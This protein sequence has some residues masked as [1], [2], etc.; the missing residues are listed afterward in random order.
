M[1]S[2]QKLDAHHKALT[3]NL[4]AS[5][6]GSFAEIGAGQEVARWF[7][8]VGGASAT[9]AKTISA[10]DKEVSD[11]LY[12]AGT[13]YVSRQRLEAMLEA[14]W[15]QLLAELNK[16]R[17]PQTRFFSFVDTVSARNYA[18]TN[19]P[20]GWVG[21]R[22]QLE[23]GGPPNDI[24]LH[25]NMLDPSN[26]LQQEAIGILGVNLIYTAFS[27][28][29]TKES[30]LAGLAQ[31]VVRERIEID[32]IDLRGSAFESW[33]LRSLPVELVHG[34]FAE[35]VFF[36]AQGPAVPPTESL[37][38]K[39]VVLAPGMFGHGDAEHSQVH[40]RLLASGIEELR[41]E[42]GGTKAA[43][44]GFFCLTA[45]SLAPDEPLPEVPD[46]LRRIDALLAAG[47]DVLLFRQ[48]ELYHMTSLVHRYTQEPVRFVAGLS[49]MI[50]AFEGIYGNL[51]GRLLE[52][53]ARL[54]AQNV[55]IYAYPMAATEL[56]ERL[57][58]VSAAGWEW[59]ET[60][61]MVSAAQL[62]RAPPL[63]H[64]FDYLLASNFLVPMQDPASLKAG[65]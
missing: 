33:D 64:L 58:G 28:L 26:L 23:P 49:L 10:Y 14:E 30:F 50:R 37:Y 55:R 54:F 53:L 52:A 59:S 20:H 8:V 24:V 29:Q 65:A 6:F 32:Y 22:F 62:R 56:R 4:D 17:G 38:K 45:A 13:R 60:N 61:G 51:E 42:L 2:A 39:A 1:P 44:A 18:G 31:D 25:V 43:P 35:A 47:G 16:T 46:L 7:F 21:L 41:K 15:T 48:G 12:G 57:K 19:D 9:V 34:G 3:L 36:P 5:V 27:G 63:G 11:D 40:M